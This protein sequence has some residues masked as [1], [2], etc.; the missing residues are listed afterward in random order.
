MEKQKLR[1]KKSS[2]PNLRLAL[3]GS[4]R[5]IFAWARGSLEINAEQELITK[6]RWPDRMKNDDNHQKYNCLKNTIFKAIEF[7]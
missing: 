7:L 5:N 3:V 4:V 1:S 2:S 6:L